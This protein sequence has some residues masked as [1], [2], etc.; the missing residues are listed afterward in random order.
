MPGTFKFGKGKN[1]SDGTLEKSLK[2]EN[3]L[4]IEELYKSAANVIR[5]IKDI[6]K[7]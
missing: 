3:G 4:K 7:N 1:G 5:N 6:V 2:K